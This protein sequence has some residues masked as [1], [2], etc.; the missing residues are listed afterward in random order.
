MTGDFSTGEGWGGNGGGAVA[1]RYVMLGG[2]YRPALRSVTRGWGGVRFS[3]KKRYVTL[4]WP[5]SGVASFVLDNGRGVTGAA[6]DAALPHNTAAVLRRAG[7][8]SRPVRAALNR[9]DAELNRG[10]A[11]HATACGGVLREL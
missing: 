7:S 1:D 10:F 6:R 4:E 11:T 3:G 2:V 8:R 5:L 9:T